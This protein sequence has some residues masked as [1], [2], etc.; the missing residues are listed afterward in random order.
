[1]TPCLLVSG[2]RNWKPTFVAVCI[3]QACSIVG[4]MSVMPFLPLFIRELGV[5]DPAAVARWAGVVT[6]APAVTMGLFSPVWGVLADKYGRK[7]MVLRATFGGTVVLVLMSLCGSVGQ[8]VVYRLLQGALTGTMTA[9]V[10]LVASV[11]PRERAGFALGTIQAMAFFGSAV[12][13]F[14][15]GLFADYFGYR[16]AFLLAAVLVSV[17]GAVVALGAHEHFVPTPTCTDTAR[18]SFAE[19]LGGTGFVAAAA[20]LFVTR[21]ANTLAAP[22]FPLFVE[23]VQGSAHKINTVTGTILAAGGFAAA[24][25]SGV[26]GR[27]SDRWG[28]RRILV[29]CSV[30][31][32]IVAGLNAWAQ[33]V[34]Q[35]LVL[36]LL[37]G[38]GS[39]GVIPSA[40]AMIR[41]SSRDRDLGKAYGVSTAATCIGWGLGPLTGGVLGAGYGLRAPF[42][43]M[44]VSLIAAAA[45]VAF[46]TRRDPHPSS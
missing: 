2:M 16:N 7:P 38:I 15:G 20:A 9:N 32:G 4:F 27:L 19:V 1:M 8:L 23:Q 13:P 39:S 5:T 45:L 24:L 40:N 11:A 33:T 3:A 18:T 36:R 29:V 28:H 22:I 10:A 14:F 42:A 25:S 21:F 17:G 30:F 31:T 46:L 43:L 26:L 41:S 37:F 35:L 44:G 6:G 34:I 12:G